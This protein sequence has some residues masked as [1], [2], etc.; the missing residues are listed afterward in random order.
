MSLFRRLVLTAIAATFGLS[1]A[2]IA[3][4]TCATRSGP[5]PNGTTAAS[6]CINATSLG[7]PARGGPVYECRN[8]QWFCLSSKNRG[9]AV[10]CS[11]DAAGAW[12]WKGS[13][14]QRVH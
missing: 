4:D 1:T 11:S 9:P 2:A 14:F 3:A 5:V 10:P 12:E 7:C 13:E 8:G 6:A